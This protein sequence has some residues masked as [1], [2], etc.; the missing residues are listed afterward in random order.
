[1]SPRDLRERLHGLLSFPVTPMTGSG[2]VDVPR[3]RE[4]LRY[5]VEH[6]PA[7]LFVCGG[8][9]E[10]FSLT[11]AEYREL[12]RAAV[13][14]V[15]GRTPVVAGIGHGTRIAIEYA[16]AA[17]DAG[18]DAALVLPPYLVVPE[19]QGLYEHYRA[20]ADSTSLAVILYQRDNVV[21]SPETVH[22]L[23]ELP[24]VIGL[25]DGYGN[26]ELLLRIRLA[27]GDDFLLLNGMPTA[28]LSAPAFS[29]VGITDYSS[30]VFNFVPE[31]ATAFYEA[32]IGED[33]G[34]AWELLEGFY[35]P[36]AEIRDRRRGY[37]VSLIK[38]GV[39]IRQGSVGPARP[40]IVDPT[41][42]E[43][44]E[45]ARVIERGLALV[46]ARV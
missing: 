46:G 21:F 43:R 36:F 11:L 25:K 17:E 5:L 30:A 40:P 2:D 8:T 19:Q 9:G 15:S 20:I 45:L 1:M 23:S 41:D 42:E 12:V 37:A 31:I 24:N 44:E 28:E 16:R 18:A 34:R 33:R 4:H 13:E 7:A 3:F 26:L 35:K 10:F 32:M 38:A 6:R 29:G 14:E 39:G 27:T 22:R